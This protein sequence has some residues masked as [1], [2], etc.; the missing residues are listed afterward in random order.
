MTENVHLCLSVNNRVLLSG[1]VAE[2]LR[3]MSFLRRFLLERESDFFIEDISKS[4]VMLSRRL[5]YEFYNS[6]LQG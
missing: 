2:M 3:R 1:N 6:I 4:C 5:R